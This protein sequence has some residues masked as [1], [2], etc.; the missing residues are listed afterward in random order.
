MLRVSCSCGKV[1]KLNDELAGKKIRCPQC[2]TV[3]AVKAPTSAAVL[4]KPAKRAAANDDDEAVASGP[5]PVRRKVA[6]PPDDGPSTPLPKKKKAIAVD[7]DD[8]SPRPKKKYRAE[9]DE[10]DED[11]DRPRKK[12]KKAEKGSPVLLI[13]LVGGGALLLLLLIGGGVGAYFLFFK[14]SST[15]TV[16]KD[17]STTVKSEA[18]AIKFHV[19]NYTGSVREV[20]SVMETTND[21]ETVVQGQPKI[22]NKGSGKIE[23]TAKMKVLGV[24]KNGHEAKVEN[25]INKISII[26]SMPGTKPGELKPGT[27]IIR[28]LTTAGF[29]ELV[30]KDG[31]PLPFEQ[32]IIAQEVLKGSFAMPQDL[33]ADD[34]VGT[35]A[36]QTAGNTWSVNA[37]AWMK[38]FNGGANN[39]GGIKKDDISGTVKF[40]KAVEVSGKRYL[41]FEAT[42]N[43][44]IDVNDPFM[45]KVKGSVNFF[46]ECR[47]PADFSTGPVK[48]TTRVEFDQTMENKIGVKEGTAVNHIKGTLT[49]TMETRYITAGDPKAAPYT[50]RPPVNDFGGFPKD[51]GKKGGKSPRN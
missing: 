2:A 41:D 7:D 22:N 46:W 38:V 17:G 48:Q 1:L 47:Y 9:D 31:K 16:N 25:T 40:V 35:T 32:Q 23:F 26:N 15:G 28:Q 33:T 37:D 8:E 20:T 44:K 5:A 14:S 45:G 43:I 39:K 36:K 3:L 34:L 4:A 13:A 12:K 49:E 30:N 50:P 6:P 10:Y 18:V 51:D 42:V 19:P 27:V 29:H 21:N 24:D 11:D